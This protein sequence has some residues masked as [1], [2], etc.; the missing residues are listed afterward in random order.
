MKSRDRNLLIRRI[1]FFFQ[2]IPLY[3]FYGL[4][5]CLP[6]TIASDIGGWIGR[7]IGPRLGTTRRIHRNLKLVWPDLSPAKRDDIT[8]GMWDNLGRTIAETP[9]LSTI[10]KKNYIDIEGDH[11]IKIARENKRPIIFVGC[12]IANWEISPLVPYLKGLPLSVVYRKPNNPF[13]DWLIRYIRKQSTHNLLMK[14]S[15]G[16][17]VL[18]RELNDGRSVGVLADQKMNDG[19]SVPFM[20]HAAMT[21]SVPFA[22]AAKTNALVLPLQLIRVKNGPYFKGVIHAPLQPNAALDTN[23]QI[24]DMAFQMNTIFSSWITAHPEQWLWLHRRWGRI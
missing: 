6:V 9:H 17:R 11:H 4:F 16:A 14:G 10:A 1:E 12:H 13:A 5:A 15:S 23:D 7:T 8:R 20:G 18:L 24:L 3:L 21:V 2:A 22:L 19:I